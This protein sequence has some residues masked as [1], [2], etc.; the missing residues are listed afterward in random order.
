MNLDGYHNKIRYDK[1]NVGPLLKAAI[2]RC[3]YILECET[4]E[5]YKT[6]LSLIQSFENLK[7]KISCFRGLLENFVVEWTRLVASSRLANKN[8]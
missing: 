6:N 5:R 8:K 2:Q 7:T 1:A 3:C 4:P